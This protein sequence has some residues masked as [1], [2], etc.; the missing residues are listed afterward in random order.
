MLVA[1]IPLAVWAILGN[2]DAARAWRFRSRFLF[3]AVPFGEFV[4]PKLMDWTADFT[5]WA[6]AASGVPVFREGNNF[7]IPS[8]RWSVVEACSG[9][10][11][12]IASLVV[13][14]LYAYLTYRSLLRR[15]VFIGISIVVPLVAN[16]LRAY[17]IVMIG[18]LSSNRLAVGVDHIIYGWVF[19][20][21]VMMAL[22]WVAG[23]WREDLAPSAPSAATASWT[24]RSRVVACCS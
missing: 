1:M 15:V 18:H 12:L 6:V 24:C 21:V 10:R 4:V 19:F 9:V 3:F 14:T 8:G 7:I 2:R 23:Y 17:M 22:F 16:W 20:G 13:G 5:V 11:Y